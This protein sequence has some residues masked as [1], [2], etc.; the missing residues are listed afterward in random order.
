LTTRRAR[1]FDG[2][3][4]AAVRR[5]LEYSEYVRAAQRDRIVDSLRLLG[6]AVDARVDAQLAREVCLRDG[7]IRALVTGRIQKEGTGYALTANI[8]N[9]IDGATVA[10]LT[11][12]VP[13]EREIMAAV[14]RLTFDLR[15]RLGEPSDSVARSLEAL[16]GVPPL[17]LNALH[18]Y[19]LASAMA[20]PAARD[21][22]IQERNGRR[23]IDWTAIE[24]LARGAV[25]ADPT[26]ARAWVLLANSIHSGRQDD[27]RIPE[28]ERYFEPAFQLVDHATPQERY[29]IEAQFHGSRAYHE[30]VLGNTAVERREHE[31]SVAATQALLALQP[32]HYDAVS[33]NTVQGLRQVLGPALGPAFNRELTLMMMR[34]AEARPRNAALNLEVAKLLLPQGRFDAARSYAARA[35]AALSPSVAAAAPHVAADIR[36]FA[37]AVAW[38]QDDPLETLRILDTVARTASGL[39]DTERRE[40]SFRLWRLY[41]AIGRF[42]QAELRPRQ[43]KRIC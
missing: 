32:D 35:A 14:R 19:A 13:R 43:L 20:H 38:L 27:T 21:A 9:P 25:E 11:E 1:V 33:E 12:R 22:P 42:R 26:F 40:V 17:S 6:R 2:T 18:L 34:A 30:A 29:F 16:H 4:D 15:A 7:G 36:L 24:R 39:P 23:R 31:L 10:S 41:L 28:T 37:A 3:I 8:V 5:E